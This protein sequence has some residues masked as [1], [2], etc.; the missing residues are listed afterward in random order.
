MMFNQNNSPAVGYCTI[1]VLYQY[2]ICTISKR[3]END[4]LLGKAGLHKFEKL[5]YVL[6]IVI[7]KLVDNP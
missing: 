6:I 4:V 1:L 3:D 5:F 2:Y 7:N